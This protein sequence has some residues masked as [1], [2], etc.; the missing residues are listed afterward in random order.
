MGLVYKKKLSMCDT[1]NFMILGKNQTTS[2]KIKENDIFAI[3]EFVPNSS[4][5]LNIHSSLLFERK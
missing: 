2:E 5:S 3:K 4:N 1:P